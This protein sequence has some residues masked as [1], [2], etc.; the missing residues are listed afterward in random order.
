MNNPVQVILNSKNFINNITPIGGGKNT[1]FFLGRDKEFVL[2]KE[3][4][5]CSI[6]QIIDNAKSNHEEIVYTNVVLQEKGWAKS[7][8]PVKKLFTENNTISV[9]GG[10]HLGEVIVGLT[11]DDL[12]AVRDLIIQ[13][14]EENEFEIKEGKLEPKVKRLRSEVGVIDQIRMYDNSDK[15]QFS[16]QQAVK[17]LQ[18]PETGRA[19]YIETFIDY[20]NQSITQNKSLDSCLE[21]IKK[22]YPNVTISKLMESWLHS[23][24]IIIKFNNND[25]L[26]NISKHEQLLNTLQKCPVIRSIYL[27]PVLQTVDT[28]TSSG[29]PQASFPS[30]INGKDY[31][32]VGIIDTGISRTPCLD[33]W[34]IGSLDFLDATVQNLSHGT[35]IGGLIAG[36]KYLNPDKLLQEGE[37]KLFDLDLYPTTGDFED[38]F[39]RGF[40]DLLQQ[41]DEMIPEAKKH[42]VR[43]FNMSLNLI[44]P[45]E[46]NNYSVFANII[47]NLS[48]KHDVIFVISAGNLGGAQS[49][50]P[51]PEDDKS[52][53]KMLAE[54]RFQGV[55]RVF[56]P[57][58]SI[59]SICVGAIDPETSS[60]R[61]IPSQYTRRGPGASF[62]QKPDVVHIGGA[63]S[64]PHNLISLDP[65]GN[66]AHGCGTSYAAPLVAKTLAN[67]NHSIN[68]YVT[69]EALKAL[70]IHHAKKPKWSTSRL[71][72][73]VSKDFI[74]F[75]IPSSASNSLM[76]SDHEI[77]MV[78]SSEISRNQELNFE[79]SWP[80]SLINENGG[81]KGEIN[82]TLVYSP[83][84]N[85][86][87]GSEFVLH[88]LDVWLRQQTQEI[89][90][91]TG[92]LI[93]ANIL[94]GGVSDSSPREKDKIKHGAKWWPTKRITQKFQ[95]KGTSS[96]CRL[97]VEPLAR[98]GFEL[99]Q[100]IPF[101]LIMTISDSKKTHDIFNEVRSQLNAT[102]VSIADITTNIQ[103]RL[104]P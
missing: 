53:L 14:P 73:Q 29:N 90:Q 31:P 66:I 57:S 45:V 42:G 28:V 97:V 18:N 9:H 25:D 76:N 72:K 50:N 52:T 47:D 20:N 2:H 10:N 69:N 78:F 1:D 59:Y 49:R 60:S 61:L 34:C 81:I 27:P 75:G 22:I 15:R 36:A 89:N 95:G 38:Y 33:Q 77:T 11:I 83:E 85:R 30:P 74:G 94:N 84:I 100:A 40:I 54:Y 39:P 70:L 32:I 96:L 12:E 44:S 93:F 23:I 67:L 6:S 71:M 5:D 19:Y 63:A 43:I 8:R 13:A 102:G 62:G 91:K 82:I 17:W 7:H 98:S 41:L 4:L 87:N 55:D 24:F 79:F 103:S 92:E 88:T 58:E 64:Y 37:C 51:W 26:E 3:E 80:K 48:K 16:T 86:L 104:R 101:T 68:R 56:Q 21:A 35:F 46:D 99:T 65:T